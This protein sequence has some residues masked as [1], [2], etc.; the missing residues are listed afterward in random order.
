MDDIR[1]SRSPD[2]RDAYGPTPSGFG[3]NA[4]GGEFGRRKLATSGHGGRITGAYPRTIAPSFCGYG[5]AGGGDNA[6]HLAVELDR[7]TKH[8][9]DR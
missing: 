1:I 4:Q 9:A 5:V 3:R 6:H 7:T 8:F 2:Q